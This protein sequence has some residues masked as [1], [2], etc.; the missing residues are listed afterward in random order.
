MT[1]TSLLRCQTLSGKRAH[2]GEGEEERG[3]AR[4]R[5]YYAVVGTQKGTINSDNPRNSSEGF[6]GFELL[7]RARHR[8][9]L[10]PTT[11][12][13]HPLLARA[14]PALV[15]DV[16]GLRFVVWEQES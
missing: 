7:K 13:S 6:Q 2:E 14:S 12:A 9:R 5:P 15:G 8:N 10:V 16:G 4:K 1:L 3:E 11:A